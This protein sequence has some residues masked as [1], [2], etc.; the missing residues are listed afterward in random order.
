[1][2][3][4]ETANQMYPLLAHAATHRQTLTYGQVAHMVGE[5]V[6]NRIGGPLGRILNWCRD[7]GHPPL[8]IIVINSLSGL[9]SLESYGSA[10]DIAQATALTHATDWY[11]IKPPTI[12]E[13]S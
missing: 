8:P 13:L 12:Q 3:H 5:P 7:N 9:P 10:E 4:S 11:T 1:M 2:N 6:A